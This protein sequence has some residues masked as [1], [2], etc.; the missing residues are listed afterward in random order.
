MHFLI[1]EQDSIDVLNVVI[2]YLLLRSHGAKHPVKIE[3]IILLS[4]SS[5]A[6]VRLRNR[7]CSM[8]YYNSKIVLF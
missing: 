5:F 2:V 6:C 8:R 1:F 4:V 7:I 3:V